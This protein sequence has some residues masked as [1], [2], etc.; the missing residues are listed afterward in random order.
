MRAGSIDGCQTCVERGEWVAQAGKNG[1]DILYIYRRADK[2]R[3]LMC[4]S[5]FF[6]SSSSFYMRVCVRVED[7]ALLRRG[8]LLIPFCFRERERDSPSFY[9]S[10]FLSPSL[11]PLFSLLAA[12]VSVR[13]HPLAR[14]RVC[15]C[16]RSMKT[17]GR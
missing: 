16:A 8:E 3:G 17:R 14:K 11:I 7:L 6:S 4:A 12:R 13:R 10:L 15:V 1:C 2:L 5:S 9:P